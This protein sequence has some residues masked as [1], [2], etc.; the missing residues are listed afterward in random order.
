VVAAMHGSAF[1]AM[2][3]VAVPSTTLTA[4]ATT[5][6]GGAANHAVTI[7]VADAGE[8][9]LALRAHPEAGGVPLI[10]SF[11]LVGGPVPTRVE[12]DFD[13]DG[14]IDFDGS[15]LDAKAF[16]YRTPGLY[17]PRVRVTDAQGTVLTSSTVVQVLDE[18]SLDVLLQ[19]KWSAL[20]QALGRNDVVGAVSLFAGASRDAYRDQLGALAGAGALGQ[21]AS[22]LGGI[23]PVRIRN[24]AAEYELRAVQRGV[25][26]SFHVLFVI[27]TDGVWRLR[28]F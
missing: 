16:I 28:A 17:F 12:L 10:T 6:F 13:G 21:V 4:V 8:S 11:S 7:G 1:A 3:P 20:R 15:A 18:T 25:P 14:Q 9:T 27:D 2:V 19:A 26:Y 22:D 5:E 24:K 23:S